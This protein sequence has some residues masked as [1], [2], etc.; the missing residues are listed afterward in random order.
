MDVILLASVT[1]VRRFDPSL[2][3]GFTV[4]VMHVLTVGVVGANEPDRFEFLCAVKA[5]GAVFSY[6][7]FSH[8]D[9]GMSHGFSMSWSA[10]S[11]EHR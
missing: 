10:D 5:M 2:A 11:F 1:K 9:L 6:R 8:R 7:G 3:A 4:E